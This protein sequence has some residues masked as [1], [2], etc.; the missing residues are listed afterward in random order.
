MSINVNHITKYYGQQKALDDISFSLKKGEICGFLG[1]N[2]AGKST[3]MKIITGYLDNYQGNVEINGIS[4]KEYP[5]KTKAVIGY[6][7]EHNPLYNDMYIRE[8]LSYVAGLY[9][10][11]QSKPKLSEIIELTGLQPEAGKKIGQLSKGYRQRVGLAQALIHN[12]E[13]LILDEPMTGLDPNQLEDIRNL[14]LEIGKNKT[15]MLSTH[16]MQEVRAVCSR[17]LII[18][19]GKLVTDKQKNELQS[20]FTNSLIIHLTLAPDSPTEWLSSITD[21]A[22][23]TT[24]DTNRFQLEILPGKDPRI[25]LFHQAAAHKSPIIELKTE[26]RNLEEI[27]KELTTSSAPL[28]M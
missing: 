9:K 19:K 22:H 11:R 26:E 4:V 17:I 5:L 15:V 16:I 10:I 8:Y 23:I 3:M 13:V 2:G 18:N 21:I 24:L 6:L 1:P 27:F 12:P 25:D 28:N 7:P 14:I 20:S